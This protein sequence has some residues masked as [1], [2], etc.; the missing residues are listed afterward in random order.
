MFSRD[1]G[2]QGVYWKSYFNIH[3]DQNRVAESEFERQVKEKNGER[4]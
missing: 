3:F 2:F 1:V 4:E